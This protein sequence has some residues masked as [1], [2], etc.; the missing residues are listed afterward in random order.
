[1]SPLYSFLVIF[2]LETASADIPKD[3][4]ICPINTSQG[5]QI[6]LDLQKE[7]MKYTT[8]GET[9]DFRQLSKSKTHR[10]FQVIQLNDKTPPAFEAIL[11]RA[12]QKISIYEYTKGSPKK[13]LHQNIQCHK[14]N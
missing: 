10:I 12:S 2:L 13:L 4:W 8:K 11:E 7:H 6:E 9:Y 3:L 14:S 5:L 1:M